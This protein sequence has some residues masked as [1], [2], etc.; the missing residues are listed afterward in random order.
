MK[1]KLHITSIALGVLFSV[2]MTPLAT[3]AQDRIVRVQ[4][5]QDA[6]QVRR[7][8]T[9]AFITAIGDEKATQAQHASARRGFDARLTAAEKGELTPM[10]TMELFQVFYIPKALQQKPPRFDTM[11][12]IIAAQA[13]MGWY[14][15][16]R[17]AD[18][19][20]RAEISSNEAFFTLAFDKSTRDFVRFMKEQPDQAAAAVKAGI[21]DARDKIAGKHINYDP[22]WPA[23]YGMLRMQCAMT[24]ATAC[25]GPSP[26]AAAEWPALLDQAAQRVGTVYRAAKGE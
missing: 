25:E 10:E 14:D 9:R 26:R 8:E 17:F 24:N 12:R 23:S 15:A 16:L 7:A 13:T 21:Q 18:D 22:T 2:F 6:W 11:L 20:G 5:L 4:T 3:H 1:S 19:S